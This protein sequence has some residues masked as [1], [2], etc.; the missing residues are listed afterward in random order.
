MKTDPREKE[1]MLLG[2]NEI[3]LHLNNEDAIMPW[4]MGGV[5][6]MA[7]KEEIEDMA[8]DPETFAECAALFMRIMQRRSAYED[9]LFIDDKVITA[10]PAEENRP[11]QE[12]FIC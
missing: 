3:I 6:D 7:S 4:L 8:N 12:T 1:L 10:F 11:T 9:G 2:M 5:P